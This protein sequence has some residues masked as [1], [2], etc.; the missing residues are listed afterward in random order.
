MQQNKIKVE[1]E[2]KYGPVTNEELDFAIVQFE[3]NCSVAKV[4]RRIYNST[5]YDMLTANI[6][7]FRRNKL[8]S[9]S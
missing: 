1:L 6:D 9:R 8:S 2:S 4:N 5:F 3:R 7:F